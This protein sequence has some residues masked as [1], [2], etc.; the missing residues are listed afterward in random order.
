MA[1]LC[2]FVD[3]VAWSAYL[4]PPRFERVP[5][6]APVEVT[7]AFSVAD[8]FVLVA[9]RRSSFF[10]TVYSARVTATLSATAAGATLSVAVR[11]ESPNEAE[12]VA[13][14]MP[15]KQI[16]RRLEISEKTVKA[17]LTRVFQELD[18]ADRT[19]AAL[20]ARQHGVT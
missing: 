2:G 15:N 11:V 5:I 10:E 8:E 20:W 19:Q 3:H 6:K 18:V 9:S 16:A 4:P 1:T 7:Y 17:H 14:G 13:A 12:M